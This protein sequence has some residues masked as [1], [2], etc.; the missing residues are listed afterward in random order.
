VLVVLVGTVVL[1]AM[2]V[3]GSRT[4][5]FELSPAGLRLRG[6]L[7]GRRLPASALRGGAARVVD[8]EREPALSPRRKTIGTALPGYRAGWFRLGNGEKA[9]VYVTDRRQ[10]VYV[11]TR[12]GYSVLLSVDRPAEFVDRLRA[13]APAA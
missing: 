3:T 2:T 13:I 11:P 8:L 7:Y 6:D 5:T 1:I 12:A 4:A 10:V 9:L